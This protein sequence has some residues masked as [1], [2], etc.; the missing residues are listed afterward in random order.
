MTPTLT[1]PAETTPGDEPRTKGEQTRRAILDEA[2]DVASRCGLHGLTVGLL[3]ERTGLS[4]SGLFAHFRSKEQL[5]VA[6][7]EHALE[8]FVT[9]VARPALR[10]P[11]GEARV[12]ALVDHWLR[13]SVDILPGGCFF[14][15]AS[16]ELDDEPGR[17]RD[18]LVQG[19]RDWLDLIANVFRTG[20]AEG[21]FRAGADPE[22]F[23]HDAYGVMLACHHARRLLEDPA[24]DARA[25][26]AIDALIAAARA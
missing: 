19:Q 17:A 4:K 10:A 1:R 18:L 22:Q 23:A 25:R 15:T 24:A 6:V 14:V 11:R 2:L 16:V 12:R 9:E 8:L 26:R 20:I 21:E 5:Q 13:W 3:A 7:V